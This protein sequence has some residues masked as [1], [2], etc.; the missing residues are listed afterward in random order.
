[1]DW[2]RWYAFIEPFSHTFLAK[3]QG[4]AVGNH[5]SVSGGCNYLVP[6]SQLLDFIQRCVTLKILSDQPIGVGPSI[7]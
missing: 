6:E 3:H 5:S 7:G 1:M 2:V 4:E